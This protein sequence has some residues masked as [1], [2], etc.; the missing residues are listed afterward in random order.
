MAKCWNPETTCPERVPPYGGRNRGH[1]RKTLRKNRGFCPFD[2]KNFIAA[3]KKL[4]EAKEL[5]EKKM[6]D[7]RKKL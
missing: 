1:C 3:G 4:W 5:A 2:Y 7:R 6:R